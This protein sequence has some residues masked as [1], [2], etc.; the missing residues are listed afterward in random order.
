MIEK[1]QDFIK[2]EPGETLNHNIYKLE[3]L[4]AILEPDNTEE[5]SEL[6]KIIKSVKVTKEAIENL[7]NT[8]DEY[9]DEYLQEMMDSTL[10]RHYWGGEDGNELIFEDD[11]DN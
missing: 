4:K 5:E 3:S 10:P 8:E 11:N 1:V 9:D 7:T 6:D 2:Q